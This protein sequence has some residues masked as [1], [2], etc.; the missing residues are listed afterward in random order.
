MPKALKSLIMLISTVAVGTLISAATILLIVQI[1][2][3]LQ[4][5]VDYHVACVISLLFTLQSGSLSYVTN[6]MFPL[7]QKVDEAPPAEP[8]LL[9][10]LEAVGKG[11]LGCLVVSL[12]AVL[13]FGVT[14]LWR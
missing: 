14:Y 12:A 9:N 3:I 13:V 7:P 1:S 6:L 4:P 8:T 5:M 11:I 2:P 10:M